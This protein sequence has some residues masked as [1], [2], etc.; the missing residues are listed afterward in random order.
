MSSSEL[1]ITGRNIK[2]TACRWAT[3]LMYKRRSGGLTVLGKVF[4]SGPALAALL[5]FFV[6]VCSI[7]ACIGMQLFGGHL[8][9]LANGDAPVLQQFNYDSFSEAWMTTFQISSADQWMSIMWS[10]MQLTWV[11]SC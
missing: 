10:V 6:L 1:E 9:G 11:R 7:F 2:L 8:G 4:R 3:L 5:G